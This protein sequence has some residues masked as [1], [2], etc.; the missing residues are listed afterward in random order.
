MDIREIIEGLGN[1]DC[2]NDWFIDTFNELFEEDEEID[3]WA[4]I[5]GKCAQFESEIAPIREIY[6]YHKNCIEALQKL[7]VPY[8]K[9]LENAL[10]NWDFSVREEIENDIGNVIYKMLGRDDLSMFSMRDYEGFIYAS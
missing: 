7:G 5:E 1:Y 4:M 9:K 8:T 10:D 6:Q 2:F 3:G